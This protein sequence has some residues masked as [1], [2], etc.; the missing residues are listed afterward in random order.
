M[1]FYIKYRK[2]RFTN[3]RILQ[4]KNGTR[5]DVWAEHVTKRGV[6][7]LNEKCAL[8]PPQA[9]TSFLLR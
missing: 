6:M 3:N 5:M 4:N 9:H 7:D 8:Q 1:I 2:Q